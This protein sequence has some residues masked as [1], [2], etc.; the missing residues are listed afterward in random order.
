MNSILGIDNKTC[1]SVQPALEDERLFDGAICQRSSVGTAFVFCCDES[2]QKLRRFRQHT[3]GRT[4]KLS[5]A[6]ASAAVIVSSGMLYKAT[7]VYGHDIVTAQAKRL[8]FRPR[9][10]QFKT[11]NFILEAI[12]RELPFDLNELEQLVNSD[13]SEDFVSF[14]IMLGPDRA[15]DTYNVVA[16]FFHACVQAI[17]STLPHVEFCGCHGVCLARDSAHAVKRDSTALSSFTR[18]VNVAKHGSLCRRD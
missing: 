9:R 12:I 8:L 17:P 15:S 11:A 18:W 14:W 16:F 13:D 2:D 10:L 1:T 4:V 3:E 5:A 7:R 6:P